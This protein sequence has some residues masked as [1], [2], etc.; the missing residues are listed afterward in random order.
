VGTPDG[1]WKNLPLD[2]GAQAL[3]GL[4]VYHFGSSIYYANANRFASEVRGLVEGATT[5][6]RWFCLT[7]GT[8]DDI[9]YS[10]SAML[11]GLVEEL[12]GKGVT[13]VIDHAQTP[14]LA[15]LRK[16]GL[17][18]LIGEEHVFQD[19]HE[20]IAAYKAAPATRAPSAQGA[21]Q[22]SAPADRGGA[23]A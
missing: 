8:I 13:L 18:D 11:R 4:L 14:A 7:A 2:S 20:L 21:S 10:G 3:P 15:E 17:L 5:P 12:R 22:E 23:S 16:D 9:D 19:L 6:V 1:D